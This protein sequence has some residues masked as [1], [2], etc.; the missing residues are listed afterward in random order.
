MIRR[1]N[2]SIHRQILLLLLML[3]SG[4]TVWA[5]DFKITKFSENLLDL[6]ASR[7]DVRDNN[8]DACALIKFSV[9][10]L[11]FEYEPNMGVVKKEQRVGETWLYVPAGTK[12]LTIRHPQL[13]ILR[14]YVIPTTIEKKV[15]Y[16][17]E[18]LI[19]DEEYLRAKRQS[20]RLF[21][22]NV[23]VGFNALSIMGPSASI[24]LSVKEHQLEL[25]AVYGVGKVSDISVYEPATSQFWGTYDYNAIRLYARY[26]YD[27]EVSQLLITPQ[28]GAALNMY[29]SSEMR[30]GTQGGLGKTNTVSATVGC[31]LSY[32]FSKAVRVQLTPEFDF[33]LKKDKGFEVLQEVDSKIKSWT[34]GFNLNAGLV[35]SF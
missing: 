4:A 30:R 29:N 28:V 21:H 18:I 6:T 5:Q 23:G 19:T 11:G 13:G 34:T 32:C 9:R 27:I 2:L 14:D 10:D 7:A 16:E 17:A 1:G 12:R 31:R 15:V 26:G 20:D 24:G 8:G 22:L 25:G 33:G 3:W 35:F